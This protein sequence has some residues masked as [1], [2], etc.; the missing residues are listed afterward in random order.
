MARWFN[1]VDLI[2]IVSLGDLSDV[3][4]ARNLANEIFSPPAR[5]LANDSR[6]LIKDPHVLQI[7]II[8][9][10]FGMD[11]N[12]IA[13]SLIRFRQ[14]RMHVSTFISWMLISPLTYL[15]IDHWH[16]AILSSYANRCWTIIRQISAIFAL[17]SDRNLTRAQNSDR[18]IK[19]CFTCPWKESKVA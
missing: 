9:F 13:N 7:S 10:N 3:F 12:M 6:W 18:F 5:L 8:Q 11:V 4:T 17:F 15:I 2:T 14:Y 16:L 1:L 19:N